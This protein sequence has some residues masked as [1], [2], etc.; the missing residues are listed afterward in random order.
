[1]ETTNFFSEVAALNI[2]GDLQL[3]IRKGAENNWIVSVMLNNEQCGDDARKLI[4][5]LN[6]KGTVNE[7]DE[8]FFER[9]TTPLQS[10]SGLLDN[11]EAF[12]KQLEEAKTQSAMEKEKADK[13]KK[14]KE[15][16]EKKFKEA[17]AK[18]D[19]LEKEGNYRDAWMKVPDPA[20]FPE[21]AEV[22]RKRKTAL[23]AKFAPDLFGAPETGVETTEPQEENTLFHEGPDNEKN[24]DEVEDNWEDDSETE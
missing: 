18:V 3:T 20:Q 10:A 7:L 24:L 21:Q 11:M 5:P 6:L 1:M 9:I 4:P 14:A 19:E 17:M 15:E 23:S 13:E 16:K 8:G 2:T 12:M 22:I